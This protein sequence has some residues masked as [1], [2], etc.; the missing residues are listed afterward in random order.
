MGINPAAKAALDLVQQARD[1]ET[2][3]REEIR[4]D[5]HVLYS[6]KHKRA[7]GFAL[8]EADLKLTFDDLTF[9]KIDLLSNPNQTEF[10]LTTTKKEEK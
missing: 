5:K 3:G 8:V 10:P 7:I 4:I 2:P 1:G 9:E 6:K